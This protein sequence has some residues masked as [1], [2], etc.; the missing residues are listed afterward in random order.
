MG[1]VID[2]K[3]RQPIGPT[4]EKLAKFEIINWNDPIA[5]GIAKVRGCVLVDG[6]LPLD[7]ALK[8]QAICEQHNAVA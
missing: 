8:F 1:Q 3:T 6:I 5:R 2:F 7:L 4:S